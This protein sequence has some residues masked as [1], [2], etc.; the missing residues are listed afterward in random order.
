MLRN[1]D[2]ADAVKR[3]GGES[4][5]ALGDAKALAPWEGLL[6]WATDYWRRHGERLMDD[7]DA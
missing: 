5:E 6:S 4:A 3:A 2:D 1:Q 7:P